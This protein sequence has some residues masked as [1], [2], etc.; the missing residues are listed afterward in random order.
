YV[1]L[2]P[3]GYERA[4]IRYPVVYYLHGGRPGSESKSH[5]LADPIQKLMKSAAIAP[6]IYVFVNGGPVS[7]YNM[8]NDDNAQGASV[9]INEFRKVVVGR[10]VWRCVIQMFF[11]VQLLAV[12]GMKPRSESVILVDSNRPT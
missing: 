7:H 5:R 8:P 1:I 2:L 10:C 4:K 11:V 6:A 9:F 12:V 3:A